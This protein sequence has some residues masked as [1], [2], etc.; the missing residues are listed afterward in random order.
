MQQ[1]LRNA[2]VCTLHT[3]AWLLLQ[4][5]KGYSLDIP[6]PKEPGSPVTSA[7]DDIPLQCNQL[8]PRVASLYRAEAATSLP[9]NNTLFNHRISLQAVLCSE[10]LSFVPQQNQISEM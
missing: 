5:H 2:S 1:A 7:A 3:S 4:Q 6:I 8:G 9:R 10:H